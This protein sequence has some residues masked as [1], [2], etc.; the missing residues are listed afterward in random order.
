MRQYVE[1]VENTL[2]DEELQE[3]LL[4]AIG[5]LFKGVKL[6]KMVA[7][8]IDMSQLKMFYNRGNYNLITA[9][10]SNSAN[11]ILNKIESDKSLSDEDKN[12]IK[13]DLPN[14]LVKIAKSKFPKIDV[15]K[16]ER[17]LG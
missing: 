14:A 13:N 6:T 15:K 7:D 12:K 1:L 16:L 5:K 9:S 4:S 2:E 10:L 11:E 17:E 8:S 3:G